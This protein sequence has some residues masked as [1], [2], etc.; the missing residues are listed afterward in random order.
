MWWQIIKANYNFVFFLKKDIKLIKCKEQKKYGNKREQSRDKKRNPNKQKGRE[1][2]V[3]GMDG[4]KNWQ[5]DKENE[6]G[7][8]DW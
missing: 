3:T 6:I 7:K 4:A 1:N 8:R 2:T 5:F